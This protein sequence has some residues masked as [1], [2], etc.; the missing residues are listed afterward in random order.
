MFRYRSRKN[1]PLRVVVPSRREGKGSGRA[2]PPGLLAL[3]LVVAACALA[4]APPEPPLPYPP[5]AR[6]RML[7]V[8]LAEWEEWGR[9][10]RPAPG[11]AAPIGAAESVRPAE[12]DPANFPRV[13]AYWRALDDDK[14]AV[15][16]N[17]SLYAAALSGRTEGGDSAALWREPAWSAAFIAFVL[18]AAGVDRRE[19]PSDAAHSA[20]VDALIRD[21]ERFPA[22]APFVPREPG[23]YAP[24]PGDLICADRGPDPI[25]HW[26]Q[27]AGDN[28]RF[29][30]MHC[31][32]VVETGE[33]FV[34]SVGGNVG[35][36][37]SR[38]RFPTDAR[39]Y[40]LPQ[41][42]GGPT[43]FAVFE[44]RLGR[45]PPWGDV[46]AP[47]PPGSPRS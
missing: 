44:N 32:I 30:P 26:R 10:E 40:L 39:G 27:R 3:P 36:A 12:T 21:A 13:L 46:S 18:R 8:A 28:G 41:P 15:A 5:A 4:P 2:P 1:T 23:G 38:T 37:V 17:R 9:R 45:L 19:F 33:G 31:D 47:P 34:L 24:A 29:R 20:Y 14:G 7:R 35:D 25:A 6:Q 11:A 16:R 43:W 42:P 22:L